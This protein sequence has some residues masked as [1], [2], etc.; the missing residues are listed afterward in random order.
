[1]ALVFANNSSLA[2]ITEL[3]SSISSGALNLI[4]TQTASGSASI[5][6]TS[7]IDSTYDV[8]VFKFYNLHASGGNQTFHFQASTNGGSSYGVTT[9]STLFLAQHDEA[10]T[11]TALTYSTGGDL[12]Q[13]TSFQRLLRITTQDDNNGVGTLIIYNPSNT[14]FVKHYLF[15]G[16]C[17][18]T[19]TYVSNAFVGGYFNTTSALNGFK[20]KFQ[21]NNIDDGI[22][23]M[24]GV[25]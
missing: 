7:G 22:I 24:Y 5:E 14:T 25:A 3:P 17:T 15:N 2:N 19:D 13:S 23:K 9:T 10:D 4:S 11:Y 8:Y 16:V 18:N 12:A 20:F 1:M 21:T 6:F